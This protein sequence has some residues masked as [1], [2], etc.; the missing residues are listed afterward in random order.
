MIASKSNRKKRTWFRAALIALLM[1]FAV[2]FTIGA[3]AEPARTPLAIDMVLV[4]ENSNRMNTS[5]KN[6][7]RQLDANGLRFDAAAALI[8]MC[9][10][11]YSRATFF[12]FNKNLFVYHET[13]TGNVQQV[14]PDDISLF[15]ISL[16]LHKTQRQN[17]MNVLNGHKIRS[18]YGTYPGADIG[19]ALDAAVKVEMRDQGNG[20]RKVIL[21]LTA[22]NNTLPESSIEQARA[23]KKLADENDIEIYCVALKDNA[24]ATILKELASKPGNYQF[25]A[26]PEDLVDV[27]RNFFADMIGSNPLESKPV[28]LDDG[29][30]QITLSIP[31][32]SVTEVNIIIP[33]Q[34]IENL[35]LSDQSG[36]VLSKSD[37]DVLVND[38]GNFICYKLISPKAEDYQ[39]KY[40]S[41]D[42]Q[43]IVVQY[44][45]SY[46]VQ[47]EADVNAK[48]INKND[49]V[50]ITA[51][52]VENGKPTTDSK[53]YGIP[54][55]V[56]VWKDGKMIE[57]KQMEGVEN[58]YQI[59]FPSL[60][61]Y[62]VGA[63]SAT[64]HFEGAGLYRD[65]EPVEFELINNAPEL[66]EVGKNGASYSV[67]I[68]QPKN[69]DSYDVTKNGTQWDLNDFV[70]DINNDA[71]T[72]EITANTVDADVSIS[73]L[74]LKVVP[75]K[76]TATSGE[77]HV[78]L[79]DGNGGTSPELVFPVTVEN[80][81][82]RYD[83]YSARFDPVKGLEKN[84]TCKVTLRLYDASGNEVRGDS[85]LPDTVEAVV[86]PTVSQAS[87]IILDYQEGAWSGEFPTGNESQDYNVTASIRIGQ[88]IVNADPAVISSANKAPVL[89]AGA[90]DVNAWEI[91]I[92]DP[93]DP[94]S[95]KKKD[96]T[97]KLSDL[98]IDPN[99]DDVKF[100][101]DPDLSTKD[102]ETTI[103]QADKTLTITS[104]TNQEANG[105]VVV[106]S[107][108]NEGVAGP[109]LKFNVVIRSV[110]EVYKKYRAELESDGKGK[111]RETK[112]TLSVYDENNLLVTGNPILP[113]ELDATITHP[114]NT[115]TPMKMVRG[116]DGK[117]TGTFTTEN[118]EV[119]YGITASVRVSDNISIVAPELEL[120]TV[121]TKPSVV[122]QLN[123]AGIIPETINIEPFL[124][125]KPETGDIVIED[126]NDY[127]TDKDGDKLTFTI[128]ESTLGEK[129]RAVISGSKLTISGLAETAPVSFRIAATDNEKQQAVSDPIEFSVKSLKKQGLIIIGLVVLGLIIL[130]LI[131]LAARPGF[132]NQTFDVF[133]QREGAADLAQGSSVSLK[134]K[135]PQKLGSFTTANAKQA[136]GTDIPVTDLNKIILKPAYSSRVKV[137]LASNVPGEVMIGT[138]KLSTKKGGAL[139]PNGML[140]VKNNG[141]TLRFHLKKAGANIPSSPTRTAPAAP[142]TPAA[143]GAVPQPTVRRSGRT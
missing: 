126:L 60:E 104:K 129:A 85:Q 61:S 58:Q 84:S 69:P 49:P 32:N 91:D 125:W 75:K 124:F 33:K 1:V 105:V 77:I 93:A 38:S 15:D 138:A 12:L 112:I 88:K 139:A 74:I 90:K 6:N 120:S 5:D 11:Q 141:V 95:Y 128:E 122:K 52:Y 137:K 117:W 22:G 71:L 59:T 101:V 20:N 87:R 30:Q 110:E 135:K 23:A 133:V 121:N 70:R 53:L 55:T 103:N 80:Y 13:E 96:K 68:N 100:A 29:N 18:G 31:N 10:A 63:Y 132:C 2:M 54:A 81:E 41:G 47:V 107:Q 111:S 108:D 72:P 46:G 99:G 65:S 140:S 37:D 24:S 86:T 43:N 64:I 62:G 7:P 44:V 76:D 8:S 114:N 21:L 143:P 17:L 97:W 48:T 131:Y 45:F 51:R 4:I 42:E 102:V 113:N 98:V 57:Q 14:K 130:F 50:T 116:E 78:V 25:A 67:T 82:D 39:L 40:Y 26:S 118:K 9:D 83:T 79:T 66:K 34:K 106:H 115:T 28:K 89:N 35:T 19:L 27:F 142:G 136:C 94:E 3:Q 123:K 56:S 127:F 119:T 16:P 73:N 92:N 36:K 109:D 134:G